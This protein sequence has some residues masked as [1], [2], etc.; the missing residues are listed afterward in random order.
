MGES[1]I[2]RG[3]LSSWVMFAK[4]RDLK[5]SRRCSSSWARESL[6]VASSSWSCLTT[7]SRAER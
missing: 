7:C 6:S 3:V 1:T 5:R 2:A 4:K